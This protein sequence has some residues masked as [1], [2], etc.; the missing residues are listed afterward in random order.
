VA[1]PF[2]GEIRLFAGTFAPRGW[3]FCDGT[4]LKIA[5]NTALFSILGTT[6]GGDGAE[7]FALPDLRGRAALHQGHGPGLSNRPLGHRRGT[8]T[9]TLQID[10]IPAHDHFLRA[11]SQPATTGSPANNFFAAGGAYRQTLTTDTYFDPETIEPTGQ[12]LPHE[13]MQPFL[14]ATYIIALE[15]IFP[16]RGE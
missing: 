14:A 6:Y 9:A 8:E 4:L 7:T 10:Q 15:G 13:N 12:G 5:Q 11:S 3:A 16:P 2:I 1:D